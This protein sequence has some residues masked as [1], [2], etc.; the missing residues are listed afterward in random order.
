MHAFQPQ[1]AADANLRRDSRCASFT[2]DLTPIT[3]RHAFAHYICKP[4]GQA[5]RAAPFAA[6]HC[7]TGRSPYTLPGSKSL[8]GC[9]IGNIHIQAQGDMGLG[10]TVQSWY[11]QGPLVTDTLQQWSGTGPEIAKAALLNQL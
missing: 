3:V 5:Q 10:A 9:N 8:R 7:F 6:A 11:Q 2:C 1:S 4:A